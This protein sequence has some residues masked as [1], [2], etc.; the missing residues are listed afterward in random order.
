MGPARCL[1][2]IA[3]RCFHGA[4]LTRIVWTPPPGVDPS[5]SSIVWVPS[6]MRWQYRVFF[7]PLP[8]ALRLHRVEAFASL[9]CL[10]VAL[11][12]LGVMGNFWKSG[13]APYWFLACAGFC[14]GLALLLSIRVLVRFRRVRAEARRRDGMLCPRCLYPI[15]D[16]LASECPE[17]GRPWDP[18]RDRA[19]WAVVIGDQAMPD[20]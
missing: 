3:P 10:A 11:A 19:L 5:W 17:C 13:I 8:P 16:E 7:A 4:R 12:V 2:E 20:Q 18:Q 1:G 14:Y 9:L 6:R 15:A